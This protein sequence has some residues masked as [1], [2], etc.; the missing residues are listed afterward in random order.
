ME[1][2][3]LLIAVTS[4][5][6]FAALHFILP[7]IPKINSYKNLKGKQKEWN[8]R[9][10]STIHAVVVTLVGLVVMS[11]ADHFGDTMWLLD[12]LSFHN[13]AFSLG[14]IIEDLLLVFCYWKEVGGSIGF[15]WHHVIAAAGY[16]LC[17]N[18]SFLSYYANFRII[19]EMSTPFLNFRWKI[20]ISGNE[21]SPLYLWNGMLLLTTFFVVR[22][23]P[24]PFL[25]ASVYKL[26]HSES[27][28]N[29]ISTTV[30]YT[31][32][33]LTA[34]LD[35]LNIYWFNLLMRRALSA[36]APKKVKKEN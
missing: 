3:Y 31:W 36:L 26:V 8:S 12:P 17:L 25:W 30:H 9:T 13:V 1:T 11:R 18:N 10:Q 29:G 24:I 35:I 23:V 22:I 27:Y 19:S 21:N 32:L 33:G 28:I 2:A 20:Y 15:V 34:G 6:F 5:S 16:T 14:Y 4:F 7:R